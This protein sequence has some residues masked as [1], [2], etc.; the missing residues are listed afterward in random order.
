[1]VTYKSLVVV[2]RRPKEEKKKHKNIINTHFILKH[3][4]WENLLQEVFAMLL[5]TVV[6]GQASRL[7]H[8]HI[9]VNTSCFY[10]CFHD[11]RCQPVSILCIVAVLY[12]GINWVYHCAIETRALVL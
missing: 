1:M 2:C 6:F 11:L 7:S 10:S 5:V 9:R 8:K 12:E 3:K 4:V